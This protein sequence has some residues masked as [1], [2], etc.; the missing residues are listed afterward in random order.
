MYVSLALQNDLT[1]NYVVLHP[2]LLWTLN[3]KFSK[4]SFMNWLKKYV[5][6]F[7][8]CIFFLP[9]AMQ[10]RFIYIP[11]YYKRNRHFQ[12]SIET[13]LLMI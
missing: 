3:S 12:C 7:F 11:G 13:K 9:S 5:F 6:H 2:N 10:Q 4:L 8:C 1:H